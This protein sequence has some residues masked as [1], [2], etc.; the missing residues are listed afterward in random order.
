MSLATSYA[1]A[2]YESAK[3]TGANAASLDLIQTQMDSFAELL[4]QSSDLRKILFGPVVTSKDKVSV[5]DAISLKANYTKLLQQFLS[6]LAQ[7]ERLVA[8]PAVRDAFTAVRLEAEGGV[9]GRLVSAEPMA[10]AD[11]KS[12]SEAFSKKLGKKVAFRVSTDP[13]LLAGIKVI[14][15]GTTYDGTLKAQLQQLRDVV[16]SGLAAR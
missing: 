4:D 1:R 6:L 9:S 15:S 7:K 12:L 5:V 14:V 2:L 3:E 11:V 13:T 16:V 10:E 8:L